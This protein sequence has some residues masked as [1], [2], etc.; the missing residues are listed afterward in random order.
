MIDETVTM[1]VLERAGRDFQVDIPSF[2][3]AAWHHSVKSFCNVSAD[4]MDHKIIYVN[5]INWINYFFRWS[6]F[7]RIL[8]TYNFFLSEAPL[9]IF[10]SSLHLVR[11]LEV[12]I[13]I[14]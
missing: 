2:V 10:P 13:C 11:Y 12:W 3:G 4:R 6:V 14:T 8:L 1:N 7:Q 9:K 5:F